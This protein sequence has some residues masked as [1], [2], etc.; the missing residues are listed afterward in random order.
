MMKEEEQL[1]H[2][3]L[4]EMVE[5]DILEDL[6]FDKREKDVIKNILKKVKIF[7]EESRWKGDERF[8]CME[9]AVS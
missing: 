3:G 2:P 6:G 5:T 4:K 9:A 7:C 1:D 8:C